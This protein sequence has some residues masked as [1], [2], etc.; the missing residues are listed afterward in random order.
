MSRPTTKQELLQLANDKYETMWNLINSM[1]HDEQVAMFNFG[2]K[3]PGGEAHWKRDKNL[4]DVLVHL[5]EWHELLLKW[6]KSNQSGDEKQFLLEGYNWKTYGDMNVELWK[7]HQN[8]SYEDSKNII[9]QSHENVIALIN[10]FSDDELFSKGYYSWIV[11]S[12]LGQYCISVT[13]SHYDWAIKKIKLHI[14]T[15]KK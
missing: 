13:S 9:K 2:N 15:C 10:R 8:T 4:R 7:K 3:L 1:S 5:Y 6:V 14:K 12:T 11:G